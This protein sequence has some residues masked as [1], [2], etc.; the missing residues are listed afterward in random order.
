MSSSKASKVSSIIVVVDTSTQ[1][2]LPLKIVIDH[3]PTNDK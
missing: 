3:P 2:S 1:K